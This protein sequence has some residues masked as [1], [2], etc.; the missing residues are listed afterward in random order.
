LTDRDL[1]WLA[2]LLEG[3]GCFSLIHENNPSKS[4]VP[5]V[6]VQMTDRDVVERA[7]ELMGGLKVHRL[8]KRGNQRLDSYVAS[9][10]GKRAKEIMELVRPLMGERRGARIDELL[11]F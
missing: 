5:D 2:G 6:R 10:R 8:R 11:V 9:T 7:A 3:E 1:G 4:T